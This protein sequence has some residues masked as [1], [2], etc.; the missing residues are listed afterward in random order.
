[1]KEALS[2]VPSKSWIGQIKCGVSRQYLKELS[3]A[4]NLKMVHQQA[5]SLVSIFMKNFVTR[6][7]NSL[8]YFKVGALHSKGEDSQFQLQG[9]L[10]SDY[11][12]D[13]INKV[14][15]ERPQS[16]IV[17]L[18]PFNLIHQSEFS[19]DSLQTVSFKSSQAVHFS[20]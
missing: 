5:E 7:Y 12:D 18:D 2:N 4:W 13:L 6:H 19:D 9:T 15:D 3:S 1:M 17:A 11:P 10:H 16:I 14:P 20:S 8:T